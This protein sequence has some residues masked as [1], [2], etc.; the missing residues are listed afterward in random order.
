[1]NRVDLISNVSEYLYANNKRK[2]VSVPRQ[3]FT[4]STDSGQSHQFSVKPS[5]REVRYT[6]EDI[7]TFLE[8]LIYVVEEA[9]K[10]GD[11]VAL[12]GFGTLGLRYRKPRW[13]YHP[14]TG[15]KID[16]DGTY[17]PKFRAGV[18]LRRCASVYGGRKNDKELEEKVAEMP[19]EEYLDE[20]FGDEGD[21]L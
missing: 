2:T 7:D 19:V 20:Y 12:H 5:N 8:A 16:I 3:V 14:E 4:I 1:M 10:D 11:E 6:K 9:L 21:E 15:E 17:L 13:V 18:D